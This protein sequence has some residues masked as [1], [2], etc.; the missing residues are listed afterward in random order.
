MERLR[1]METM[2]WNTPAQNIGSS[3]T[4]QAM[5]VLSL[6]RQEQKFSDLNYHLGNS[7]TYSLI[8]VK[9]VIRIAISMDFTKKVNMKKAIV[10]LLY[11][12]PYISPTGD[13]RLFFDDRH[14][15]IMKGSQWKSRLGKYANHE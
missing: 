1:R 15:V 5:T 7:L 11:D 6:E 9:I 13:R 4:S 14:S 2:R 3:D 8:D 10:F 12:I